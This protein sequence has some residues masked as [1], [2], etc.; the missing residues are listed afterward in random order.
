MTVDMR[1]QRA[2]KALEDAGYADE[3]D[4]ERKKRRRKGKDA[5]PADVEWVRA[6][7]ST[8]TSGTN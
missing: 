7:D 6:I 8:Q 5:A 1:R 3:T 4:E 2:L